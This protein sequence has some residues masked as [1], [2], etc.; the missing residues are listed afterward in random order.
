MAKKRGTQMNDAI[1]VMGLKKSYGDVKAVKG[2]DFTVRKGTLFAFLGPNGAGK[3][4]TIDMLSTQLAPDEG[5]AT[6]NG[7]ALSKQDSEIRKSI[8][9]VFQ[10]SVLDH[11]LTVKENLY[12]RAGFYTKD[13]GKIKRAV[14]RAADA[15]DINEFIG[16][17][18]G[19]LSGG[20][21][22]RA[23]IARALINTPDILFLDE[24]TTGLDPNT[25][26][27]VWQ[28]IN[29]LKKE[30]GMTIFLTTHY[31]E[32]AAKA[33]YITIM[34]QGEIQASG[35]P[36]ELKEKYTFDSIRIVPKEMEAAK[37]LLAQTN[38][39]YKIKGKE[40]VIKLRHTIDAVPI[41]EQLKSIIAGFEVVRGSMDDVFLNITGEGKPER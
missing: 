28:T 24:P 7:Y 15:T 41:I 22:R 33:D 3:S 19:K 1:V 26:K 14:M 5:E 11:L 18:Y 29:T 35:T 2:I 23:D 6:I 34:N 27:N 21:R 20:Q 36:I 17:P 9:I 4:T 32:E 37:K 13:R 30:Q 8:G 25:R 12:F 40:L 10:D 39:E 16:R 31:M 38:T